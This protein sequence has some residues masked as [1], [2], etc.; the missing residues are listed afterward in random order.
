MSCV[1]QCA[2]MIQI[3]VALVET[4]SQL[5]RKARVEIDGSTVR[6]L[7]QRQTPLLVLTL[8]GEPETPESGLWTGSVQGD[9]V[10]VRQLKGCGCGGTI[11]MDKATRVTTPA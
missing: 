5:Y 7:S 3:G 6:I 2:P 10:T 1:L 4:S 8:D 9:P 11:V